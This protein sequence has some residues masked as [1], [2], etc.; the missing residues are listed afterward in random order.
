MNNEGIRLLMVGFMGFLLGFIAV[1]SFGL[2]IYHA[3]YS[4]AVCMPQKEFDRLASF[5]TPFISNLFPPDNF[6]L[7]WSGLNAVKK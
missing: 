5:A 4:D 2:I 6:T 3:K 1:M 7:N